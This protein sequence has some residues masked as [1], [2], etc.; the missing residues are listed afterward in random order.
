MLRLGTTLVFMLT[1]L[2]SHAQPGDSLRATPRIVFEHLTATP[3]QTLWIGVSFRIDDGW[4]IYWD[5]I[6]DSGMAVEVEVDLPD[7]WRTG[8]LQWPAPK[9]YFPSEGILDHIY[10]DHVTLLLPVEVPNTAHPGRI[11]RLRLSLAW[12]VCA[13]LCLPE[14]ADVDG[15]ILIGRPGEQR[16]DSRDVPLFREA[17][18]RL[19]REI[20]PDSLRWQGRTLVL[21][22]SD[23]S[24]IAFYPRRCSLEP[25]SIID[26]GIA[27]GGRLA[28]RFREGEQPVHGVMEVW[29]IGEGPSA[30]YR[31]FTEPPSAAH[32]GE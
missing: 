26:E 21:T 12:L 20:P 8:E 16:R 18:A 25:V 31:V 19:P 11:E 23:A 27:D 28:V 3:G 1:P 10:E 30:V 9:R 6:N 14:S 22:A 32:P 13:D 4:H 15:R 5:G 29:P 2:H 24:R 17:R 7:G